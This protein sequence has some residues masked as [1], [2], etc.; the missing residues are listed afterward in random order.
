[1]I[2]KCEDVFYSIPEKIQETSQDSSSLHNR[3]S[4][5]GG[6][7]NNL[8]SKRDQVTCYV[9]FFLSFPKSFVF[10]IKDYLVFDT[11]ITPRWGIVHLKCRLL[12]CTHTHIHLDI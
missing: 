7:S 5:I 9:L 8:Y 11:M 3:E 12:L 4:I 2:L 1:M 6:S 10:L